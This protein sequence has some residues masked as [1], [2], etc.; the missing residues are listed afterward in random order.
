MPG[1]TIL[2]REPLVPSPIMFEA[3]TDL[4][5][6]LVLNDIKAFPMLNRSKAIDT[7]RIEENTAAL[8]S[9]GVS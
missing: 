4:L 5:A 6:E 2:A 9:P 8:A 3:I 7:V 1:I